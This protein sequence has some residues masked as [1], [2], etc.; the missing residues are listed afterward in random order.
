MMS[1][2]GNE[3]IVEKASAAL[4]FSTL[5]SKKS[6]TDLFSMFHVLFGAIKGKKFM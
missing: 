1:K 6:V 5:L 3:N 4:S 2:P